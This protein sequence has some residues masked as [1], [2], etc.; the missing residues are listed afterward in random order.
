MIVKYTDKEGKRQRQD[1]WK[2][3]DEVKV[4]LSEDSSTF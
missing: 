3:T 2:D 1:V 4:R